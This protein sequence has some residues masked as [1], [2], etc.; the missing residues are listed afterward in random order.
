MQEREDQKTLAEQSSE[1]KTGV[2]PREL[3]VIPGSDPV[4]SAE[5]MDA[6]EGST[7][8]K[9]EIIFELEKMICRMQMAAYRDS[10]SNPDLAALANIIWVNCR[11]YQDAIKAR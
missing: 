7:L 8:V 4:I 1:A 3:Q 2:V 6:L 5:R 9:D 11:R 10:V